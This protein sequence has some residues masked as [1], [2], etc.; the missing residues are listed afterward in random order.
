[1]AEFACI[2][3]TKYSAPWPHRELHRR[4]QRQSSRASPPA[5][6]SVS[7]AHRELHGKRFQQLRYSQ[8]HMVGFFARQ[9]AR[10]TTCAF[11]PKAPVAALACGAPT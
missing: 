4:P 1:M 5:H 9:H 2:S 7:W 6:Y 3:P 8:Q 10:A 11:A